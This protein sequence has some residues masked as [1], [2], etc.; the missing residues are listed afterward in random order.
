MKVNIKSFNVNMDVKNKGIEFEV[1]SPDGNDHRG[2]CY[3]TRTGLTWCLRRKA[4]EN[5]I[6]LTWDDFMDIMSSKDTLKRALKAA[7]QPT[8]N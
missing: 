3:L 5:G 2:D 8:E 4:K 7:R 1:R 6:N